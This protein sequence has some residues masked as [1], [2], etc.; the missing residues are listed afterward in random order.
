MVKKYSIGRNPENLIS[1]PDHPSVSGTHAYITPISENEMLVEDNDSTNGTFVNG[2]MVSSYVLHP[3]DELRV[4]KVRIKAEQL[5]QKIAR[6]AK[7]AGQGNAQKP[8]RKP[9]VVDVSDQ[10]EQLRAVFD[11]YRQRK[12]Q[13]AVIREGNWLEKLLRIIFP[14]GSIFRNKALEFQVQKE[15]LDDWFQEV[16]VCPNCNTHFGNMRWELI[17][18]KKN[19]RNCKAILVK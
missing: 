17:A 18:K 7:P 16:Y 1:I 2:Q 14:V 8:Q 13:L 15:K 5:F 6:Q 9:Q 4:G 19:C 11:K 10:F 12:H 3:A